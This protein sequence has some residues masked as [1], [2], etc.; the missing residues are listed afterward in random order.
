MERGDQFGQLASRKPSACFGEGRVCPVS[1]HPPINSQVQHGR[2]QSLSRGQYRDLQDALDYGEVL[3]DESPNQS[4]TLVVHTPRDADRWRRY[5][6][7]SAHIV[8]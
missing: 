8:F 3:W 5:A 1:M 4:P 6:D 7:P 2:R